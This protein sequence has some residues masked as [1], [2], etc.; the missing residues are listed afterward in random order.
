MKAVQNDLTVFEER[1]VT[2]SS[3]AYSFKVYVHDNETDITLPDMSEEMDE[4]VAGCLKTSYNDHHNTSVREFVAQQ[5]ETENIYNIPTV[6]QRSP[7]PFWYHDNTYYWGF[8]GFS[9]WLIGC[10]FCDPDEPTLLFES[11]EV[12]TPH[13]DQDW[14]DHFC[15]CLVEEG[16][17]GGDFQILSRAYDCSIQVNDK[18]ALKSNTELPSE[19]QA[20]ITFT[21]QVDHIIEKEERFITKTLEDLI[22]SSKDASDSLAVVSSP[23]VETVPG[24]SQVKYHDNAKRGSSFLRHSKTE[25]EYVFSIFATVSSSGSA[26]VNLG[27]IDDNFCGILASG[28]YSRLKSIV[29]CKVEVEASSYKAVA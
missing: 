19:H 1:N 25:E 5:I 20:K 17:K 13:S 8:L 2:M 12:S 16:D 28:P 14:E 29:G 21:L 10:N 9:L 26:L 3:T 6:G 24:T 7:I 15:S 4:V 11:K 18:P 23:T 27:N 22:N